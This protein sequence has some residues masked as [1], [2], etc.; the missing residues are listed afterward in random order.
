MNMLL[1]VSISRLVWRFGMDKTFELLSNA[2]FDAFDIYFSK[3]KGVPFPEEADLFST[4]SK[5]QEL[6]QK[7]GVVCAQTHANCRIR[8]N[9]EYSL[10]NPHFA[11]VVSTIKATAIV[12]AKYVVVHPFRHE[13]GSDEVEHLIEFYRALLPYAKKYGIKIATENLFRAAQNPEKMNRLLH[14]VDDESFV[15]CF[16]TGHASVVGIPP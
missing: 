4:A 13:D 3:S 5:L 12:G 10:G 11:E 15:L 16:D 9:D 14:G 7:T 6:M 1:S 8:E 2:G